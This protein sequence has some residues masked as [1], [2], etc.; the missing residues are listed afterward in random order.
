MTRVVTKIAAGIIGAGAIVEDSHLPAL[1]VS[2][3][4]VKWVTD[5][6]PRRADLLAAMY[7]TRPLPLQA[8]DGGLADVDVCLLAIPY[9]ARR[10]YIES[11]G[12]KGKALYVEKPFATSVAEHDDYCRLFPAH[13]LAVGFQRRFHAVVATLASI[14]EAKS[15][16]E[17]RRIDFVQGHFRIKGGGTYASNAQVSGGGVLIDSAIHVLDQ[18]LFFTRANSVTVGTLSAVQ[19][20]G[21][22]FD[23]RIESTITGPFGDCPVTSEVSSIRNLGTRLCLHFEDA[24]VEYRP[25]SG[26]I[27]TRLRGSAAPL[28][29]PRPSSA[30]AA[31]V[32]CWRE[33]LAGL[34]TEAPNRTSAITSRLT[35]HWIEQIYKRIRSL[36][37]A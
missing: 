13:R 30:N 37:C 3:V 19:R 25:N 12:A 14:I 16:G 35:T 32:R 21:I 28:F 9:G 22:D 24:T 10:A 26:M 11:C 4:C 5:A 33:F 8:V 15:Y 23:T 36:A 6:N 34:R 1:L 27:V 29:E 17:L 7:G 2:D 18:I 31:F 20:D